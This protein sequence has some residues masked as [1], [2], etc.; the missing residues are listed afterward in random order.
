MRRLEMW[1]AERGWEVDPTVYIAGAGGAAVQVRRIG[2]TW[3]DGEAGLLI[4]PAEKVVWN[5]TRMLIAPRTAV[6]VR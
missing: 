6:G 3:A 1:L 4:L 2:T 5:G